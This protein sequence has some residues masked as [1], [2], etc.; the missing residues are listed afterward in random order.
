MNIINKICT[1]SISISA[2][3]MYAIYENSITWIYT[4]DNLFS[5]PNLLHIYS[6]HIKKFRNC[7]WEKI[8]IIKNNE[9]FIVKRCTTCGFVRN[10]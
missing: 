8:P 3:I 9:H 2:F 10:K 5:D 4:K 1:P 7:S 6:C